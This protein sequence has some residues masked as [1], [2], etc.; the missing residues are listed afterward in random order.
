MESLDDAGGAT[1]AQIALNK[2][3]EDKIGK[4]WRNMEES[5]I[6]NKA[7]IVGLEKKNTDI[8]SEMTEQVDQLIKW[9]MIACHKIISHQIWYNVIL[10]YPIYYIRYDILSKYYFT[11]NIILCH[12]IISHQIWYSA[13]IFYQIC[14]H[15]RILHFFFL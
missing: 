11:W 14:Y 13:M 5:K 6:Y 7:L 2:K 1:N 15:V 12:N 3:C 10:S 4:L 8:T 9:N